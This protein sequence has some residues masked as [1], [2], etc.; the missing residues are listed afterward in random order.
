MPND[1]ISVLLVLVVPALFLAVERNWLRTAWQRW[2]A[3]VFVLL[4]LALNFPKQ[5]VSPQY[6]ERLSLLL[7]GGVG[8][9]LL[10]RR[11]SVPWTLERRTYL[12][13]LTVL[14]G[15]ALL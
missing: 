8:L 9:L 10:L 5:G 6:V 11:Y 3:A 1:F 13:T 12:S 15:L 14:A 2:L 4:A 7:A